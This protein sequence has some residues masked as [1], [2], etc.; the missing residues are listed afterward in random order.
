MVGPDG[1]APSSLA[2]RA[3]A[4]LLSYGPVAVVDG[5]APLRFIIAPRFSRPFG[6]LLPATTVVPAAGFAPA[7]I[8]LEGGGLAVRPRGV[9]SSRQDWLALMR[10]GYAHACG[11]PVG[12]LASLTHNPP[13]EAERDLSFTTRGE[14]G[15]FTRTCTSISGFAGPRPVY[16]TMKGRL[17]GGTGFAPAWAYA[18]EF[19]RLVC[20]H[21]TTRRGRKYQGPRDTDKGGATLLAPVTWHLALPR[22]WCGRRELPFRQAQGPERSRR[23][24]SGACAR[25]LLGPAR[26]LFVRK[27][28]PEGHPALRTLRCA[29]DCAISALRRHVR[30]K[31]IRHGELR[32]ALPNTTG[33]RRYLRFAGIKLV[34]AEGL[35]PP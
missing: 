24:P 12:L 21:S 32:S 9:W 5:V 15:P 19:L 18:R 28:R 2:Y 33:I 10:S 20:I 11:M 26:L 6:K 31:W 22:I 27:A 17:V 1:N 23:T 16:W 34:E 4:L 25:R 29:P 30:T 3:R 8:R 14:F 7:S 35:A 13:F